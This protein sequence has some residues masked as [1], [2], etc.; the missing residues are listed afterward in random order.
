MY[1][2][3]YDVETGSINKNESNTFDDKEKIK[4]RWIK[5]RAELLINSSD[6]IEKTR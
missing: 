4:L 1:E 3:N 2:Y 5:D 6:H